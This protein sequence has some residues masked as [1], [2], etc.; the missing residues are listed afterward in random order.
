MTQTSKL[1]LVAVVAALLGGGGVWLWQNSGRRAAPSVSIREQGLNGLE[2]LTITDTSDKWISLVRYNCTLSGGTFSDGACVC[3]L[4]SG[5]TREEMYDES[6]GYC[7][8]SMG[9]EGGD[10]F[11][12]TQ[13]LPWGDYAFWTEIVGNNCMEKGGDWELARCTCAN[14]LTY[15]T[16]TGYCK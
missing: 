13:G 3:P 16:S 8:S 10:A 15:D 9:G 2:P 11:A 14:G 5:Q 4:E 1:I 12:T 6:T 7:R